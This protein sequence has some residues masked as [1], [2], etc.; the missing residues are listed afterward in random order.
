MSELRRRSRRISERALAMLCSACV[1]ALLVGDAAAVERVTDLDTAASFPASAVG[2]TGVLYVAWQDARGPDDDLYGQ[3]YAA[4]GETLWAPN[5][6]P[7]VATAR[8]QR[9]P[10]VTPDGEGGVIVVWMDARNGGTDVYAQRFDVAG[11]PLWEPADGIPVA[12]TP[13]G[14]DDTKVVSDGQSGC[15]IAWED[16]RQGNQDIFGQHLNSDGEAMWEPDGGV[17]CGAPGHQYDPF[18]SADGAGG[19]VVA[20]WDVAFPHWRVAAQR[21]C[22]DGARAW[23]DAGTPVSLTEGNQAAPQIVGDTRGGAYVFWVDYRADGGTFT[24]FDLYS[25]HVTADGARA[26][27]DE[28]RPLCT[29]I[30]MQ[31]TVSAIPDGAGGAYIAWTDQRELFD[32]L[33]AQRLLADASWAWPAD[34]LPVSTERGRQRDARLAADGDSLLVAWYDY[35]R[36]SEDATPQDLYIQRFDK[37][38]APAMDVGGKPVVTEDGVR[39]AMQIHARN[40]RVAITWMDRR[41]AGAEP[42][43]HAWLGALASQ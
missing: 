19:V 29:A 26:W 27:G 1:G 12:V 31:Q 33:Y 11:T 10:I 9:T 17:V 36:E 41:D 39:L 24:N 25:Q 18:I 35:R 38:G 23:P 30:G 7:L 43:V 21:M 34:G 28:G 16:W 14:K 40:G 6:I 8:N 5:G 3:A 37:D 15:F 4:D 42:D 2:S 13:G 20:W 22:A 32:D